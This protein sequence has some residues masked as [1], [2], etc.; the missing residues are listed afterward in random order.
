VE[1]FVALFEELDQTTATHGKV[2]AL[3]EYFRQVP[4]ADAAWSLYLLTGRKLKRLAKTTRLRE[5]AAASAGVPLWLFEEC[6]DNLGDLAETIALLTAG[7]STQ[8]GISLAQLI[9]EQYLPLLQ[10]P[11]EA[12]AEALQQMWASL[13]PR[14]C[15]LYLKLVTGGF[16]VGVS[17][18]L[19]IRALAQVTDQPQTQIAHRLSGSWEPTAEFYRCLF[20]A[21]EGQADPSRPYPF[22]LAYPLEEAPEQLGPAKEWQAE[23]KWD[24]I[25]A[26]LIRRGGETFLWSRGEELLTAGFPDLIAAAAVLPEGTVLDG[27]LLGWLPGNEQ[28]LPFAELQKRITRKTLS[29][30]LL[31]EIPAR[32]VV[33]DLLEWEGKDWRERPLMARRAQLEMLL[34]GLP[35]EARERLV[36][37][38]VVQ[39]GSWAELTALRETARQHLSEGLM[40]KQ[41]AS[42][43]GTGRRRGGWWKWK[44]GA[45]TA[46]AVMVYAQQGHGR[47]AG[48]YTD[49]TFAIWKDGRLVPFAKAYSGLTDAEIREVDKFIR[50]HTL[51]RFGPVRTVEP[52]MVFELAFE[53]I[54]RS[55]RH[56]SGLAVRFPRILR[57]RT[58]KRPDQADSY[59][60]LA[61]LLG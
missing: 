42:S 60:R 25:R 20:R 56:K 14:A 11:E 24:G 31:R 7:E 12:R 4:D 49:Y 57:I 61:A 55:A 37:S 36:P 26:Q 8:T 50:A 53:G 45:L 51:E 38:P 33:Y 35:E 19:V 1:A 5:W 58:D 29:A 47:R 3:V 27:E 41:R 43:Y 39:A 23:W 59:E 10:L 17:E 52:L 34:E 30:K 46:D 44:V 54:Q 40:L 21:E 16:R 15:F 6:Y 18:Q 48:L 13:S 22:F 32:L 9:E 2:R 28:P